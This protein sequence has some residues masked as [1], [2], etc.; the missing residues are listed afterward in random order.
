M[1]E[2]KSE[3]QEIRLP[4]MILADMFG[5]HLVSIE[6]DYQP[7][8]RA[9]TAAAVAP[10]PAAPAQKSVLPVPPAQAAVPTTEDPKP[11]PVA[12]PMPVAEP[13]PT[14]VEVTPASLSLP[15]HAVLG[16]FKQ[17]VLL[18]LNEPNAVHCK[19]ADLEFLQKVIASVKLSMDHIAI[20]NTHG[21]QVTYPELKAQLPA[22]VALYFGVEPVSIG[23]P[24]RIPYFQVQPWDDCRFLYA[25]SLAEI[26]GNSPAQVEL[27][28]QLWMALKKIFG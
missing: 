21:K 28:K 22:K 17:Q 25:P 2:S 15:P 16:N 7:V 12:L 1:S 6:G 26:N 27:K 20:L 10:P 5:Q 24:M 4:D 19:D 23:V 13:E 8:A 18:I 11:A 9:S 14:P 3:F